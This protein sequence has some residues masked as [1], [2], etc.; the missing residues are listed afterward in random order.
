MGPE[1]KPPK[2]SPSEQ[3][4]LFRSALVNLVDPKHPLVRLAGLIDWER[5]ATAFGP[6]YRD[7]VGRPGL[8]T[9]LM[10]G[11][12]LIKHMDGLSDAAVCAGFLDSPSV[13]LC[14]GESHVQHA[15][16]RDRSLMTRWRQR[17]GAERLELL[18]A[19][20]LAAAQRAGVAEV[21][22]SAF[23]TPL[24][25]IAQLLRQRRDDRGREK[26]YALHAPEV[27]C[28]AGP[29]PRCAETRLGTRARARLARASNSA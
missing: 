16:S 19:E 20:T 18:L 17:I 2:S 27:E 3:P 10:V 15:L 12:H 4:E 29:Q 5:F 25:R 22:R 26:I 24:A 28:I 21:V 7:G 23:A 6:L 13:P 14:C 8:P 9:R 1:P 11:L